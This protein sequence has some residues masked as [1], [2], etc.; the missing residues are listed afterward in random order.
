M[1]VFGD[2]GQGAPVVS[3]FPGVYS[4]ET[5]VGHMYVG[6]ALLILFLPTSPL[7]T[8][9]HRCFDDA[10]HPPRTLK[11]VTSGVTHISFK[12]ADGPWS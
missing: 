5:S 12:I 9:G 6:G 4:P 8:L 10:L 1:R 3:L 7:T 2:R 11:L